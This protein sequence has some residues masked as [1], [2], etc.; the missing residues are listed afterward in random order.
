MRRC[1]SPLPARGAACPN[2]PVPLPLACRTLCQTALFIVCSPRPSYARAC[3][4]THATRGERSDAANHRNSHERIPRRFSILPCRPGGDGPARSA[5]PTN[6]PAAASPIEA[7]PPIAAHKTRSAE[8]LPIPHGMGRKNENTLDL[9]LVRSVLRG[10]RSDAAKR[11]NPHKRI[12][13]RFSTLPCRPG[14]DGPA[15]SASPAKQPAAAP[16]ETP[17]AAAHRTRFAERRPALAEREG[18]SK[19]PPFAEGKFKYPPLA[20]GSSA[21]HRPH[22]ASS[23]FCAAVSAASTMFCAKM[24]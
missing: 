18:K 20:A 19:P 4:A 17:P 16:I 23:A 22:A 1:R 14:G 12:P 21:A 24:A 11:R 10:E 9:I 3:T 15:R 13:R 5:S 6:Q 7:P 8:R 2:T